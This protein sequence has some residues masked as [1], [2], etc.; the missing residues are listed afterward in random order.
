MHLIGEKLLE[1]IYLLA[2]PII[3][4]FVLKLSN[5][6]VYIYSTTDENNSYL[7]QNCREFLFQFISKT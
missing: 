4:F 3:R 2:N 7:V 6:F 5:I 1:I